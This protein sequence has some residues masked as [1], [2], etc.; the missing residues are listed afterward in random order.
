MP[1]TTTTASALALPDIDQLKAQLAHHPAIP[2]FRQAIATLYSALAERFRQGAPIE[3][4]VHLRASVMDQII[5]AAWQH[6]GLPTDSNA[7]DIMLL[8]VGGYGRGELLP[9][10]DI[11]LWVVLRDDNTAHEEALSAFV[12]LLWDIGLMPGH[13]VRTLA[14]CE[15]LAAE[16]LTVISA[17]LE[18]RLLIGPPALFETLHATTSTPKMWTSRAFFEAK[19]EE[20]RLRHGKLNHTESLLEPNV[21]DSPGGLRDLHTIAW[22]AR[23]HY[24]VH[25]LADAVTLG[26]MTAEDLAR[27]DQSMQFLWRLRFALHLET[28][29]EEDRLLFEHQQVI[30]QQLGFIDTREK[31]AVE[32]LMHVYYQTAAIVTE[33]NDIILLHFSEQWTDADAN[34][35][36]ETLD[37]HFALSNGHIHIR[38]PDTFAQFPETL[39]SLFAWLAQRPDII[40]IR[41]NTLRALCAQRHLIDE[42]YRDTPLH[43]HIFMLMMRA[44]GNIPRTLSLMARYGILGRYLPQFGRV[45]GLMQY[46][47]FH[48][49]TV[50]AHTLNL[51]QRL[52]QFLEGDERCDAPLAIEIM[53]RLRKREVLWIAGL[54]HD[55]GKGRGGNHSVLGAEDV[56]VFC[57]RHGL[58]AETTEL[59][60]WLVL[61]HLLMSQ[62]AQKRDISEPAVIREFVEIVQDKRHLATLYLL[63]VA[64]IQATNPTL[65]NG[66]RSAL[67]RQLFDEAFRVLERGLSV[68]FDRS[69]ASRET[70]RDAWAMLEALGCN[71][72]AVERC[73]HHCG[74]DYFLPYSA[75]EIAWQ[76]LGIL[77]QPGVPVIMFSTPG[78]DSPEGGTQVFIH[79]HSVNGLFA[80]IVS[81][82]DQL[83]LSVHDAR[84]ITSSDDWT[85]NTFTLLDS[86]H[87]PVTDPVRLQHI[88]T[89]LTHALRT[90]HVLPS[91]VTRHTSRQLR[92]FQVPTQVAFREDSMHRGSIL[93]VEAADRP[94]LLARIGRLF[95][96]F[97]IS[98]H[99]AK[100]ST[101]GE[102]VEDVFFVTDARGGPLRDPD[103]NQRFTSRVKEVLD[104]VLGS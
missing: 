30:A 38:S 92:H 17:L 55:L 35:V 68:P 48:I 97:D 78:D 101:L 71:M 86:Q 58:S 32:Q 85:L 59:A 41:A 74:E 1:D 22:I 11:D 33:L 25:T 61:N 3:P 104:A 66:W 84:I 102:R 8:A 95:V 94:G 12:M 19:R 56:R 14:D 40:G 93:T 21:K 43:Q 64:D 39:L 47:L 83:D 98:V 70:R 5:R 44:E 87:L 77:E 54:F 42:R 96:E 27:Y 100:I 18:S 88:H 31:L 23:R 26:Y 9:H 99:S 62:T 80:A 10:S 103:F 2:L 29:R 51:L 24:G 46:D 53:Q 79:T 45:N 37:T 81:T 73:W 13:C 89:V 76:T 7:T 63:T 69:D 49:Y 67:L 15:R 75:D 60:E 52:Q 34:D 4:L 6:A 16:D 90:P 36:D 65:W 50:G 20:Q 72:K 28:N 91:I 82:F 57:T